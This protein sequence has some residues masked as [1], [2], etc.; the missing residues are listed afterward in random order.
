M[1]L[2]GAN[3]FL[4]SNLWSISDQIFLASHNLWANQVNHFVDQG[5]IAE[6][7]GQSIK[8]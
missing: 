7:P 1:H 3:D 8:N 4:V 5:L 2:G 6:E